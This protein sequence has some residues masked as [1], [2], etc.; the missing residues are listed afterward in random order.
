VSAGPDSHNN[1]NAADWDGIICFA[2]DWS[3]DPL[4]KK[5][6]MLR[7]ARNRRILWINSVN[8]RRPR[9]AR[10]DMRRIWEKLAGFQ[11]GLK[12]VH[13][14]IWVLNPLY[15]PFHGN[16]TVRAFNRRLLGMQIRRALS[17]LKIRRP[18]TYTFAPTSADV[19][20]TLGEN[21]I[22][23]HCV[24]EFAAFSDAGSEVAARER[25]LLRK[26]DIVLCSAAGLF[27]RKKE[28]NPNTYLVT[29]GVDYDFFRKTADPATPVAEELK[30]LPRPILGFTGLLADWVDLDVI[31]EL[32]KRH[33]DWSLVLI[34]RADTDLSALDGLNNVHLLGHRPYAR[35]PEYLRGFDIALLPFVNNE[36]T[37]NANPLKLREYMAAGL[38]VV[39]SPIPEV[40]RYSAQV[41]LASTA[42]E[43]ER[44]ILKLMANGDLGPSLARSAQMA[45]E[46]W[47]AKVEQIEMLLHQTFAAAASR[48]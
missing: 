39:A 34:G 40:A 33:P 38:P 41:S 35:L 30:S 36:L 19:A 1:G 48:N 14:S 4:S 17:R 28:H 31:A 8:N 26:S 45:P 44:E 16:A 47:D 23:Y 21:R 13:D 37:V 25:E 24:D 12:Q 7:F 9:L 29:H 15:V 32:A 46:S 2:N 10:K 43:Y 3:A 6:L 42:A 18:V 5:H 27:D 11:Q 22:V 20:G